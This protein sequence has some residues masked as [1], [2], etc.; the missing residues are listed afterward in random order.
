MPALR[1][2]WWLAPCDERDAR[3]PL[4]LGRSV[5]PSAWRTPR[6]SVI[7]T[8]FLWVAAASGAASAVAAGSIAGIHSDWAV[9]VEQYPRDPVIGPD[10][11][12]YFAKQAA[13]RIVRFDPKS[14]AFLEWSLP[15]GSVPK[16]VVVTRD[17]KVFYG[18][19]GRGT[20]GELDPTTG[21]V[22]EFKTS[23]AKS[24]PYSLVLDA[25]GNIWFALRGIYAV[26]KLD[27]STGRIS[28]YLV[29]ADVYALAIDRQA[30][31]WVS[32]MESD[33]ISR[34]D[35]RN[36]EVVE[37]VVAPGTRPRRL[38]VGPD[39]SVWVTYYGTGRLARI[40]PVAAKI[41]A[42]YLLPGG[43]NGGPYPVAVDQ[44][45]RVWVSEF[46]SNQVVVFDPRDEKFRTF[47]YPTP[48]TGVRNA[49]IDAAGR[50]WYLGGS[51]GR[52]G[53]IE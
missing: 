33:R 5:P 32:R 34:L 17:G 45:G 51:N 35:P 42:E 18:A 10:G 53:F 41:V 27:R 8:V 16:G 24:N 52:L 15:K 50:Y 12:V 26:G 46:Q 23:T 3:A 44:L 6:A 2:F 20:I 21:V 13:D 43:R 29:G 11:G 22:R 19:S 48:D 31:V 1:S 49:V 37:I 25:A 39:G 38:A 14:H 7:L 30:R 36:G 40:D 47:A 9:P 28:E 4:A